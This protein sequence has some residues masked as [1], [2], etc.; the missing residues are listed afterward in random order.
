M[1]PGFK[2]TDWEMIAEACSP[3][4]ARRDGAIQRLFEAYR[5]PIEAWLRQCGSDPQ[6]SGELAQDFFV[7]VIMERDL[8]S[9]ADPA[10]GKLRIL[11]KNAARRYRIDSIR[12]ES[13]RQRAE[14]G[15]AQR[16]GA[17]CS[18]MPSDAE[19]DAE[20][21]RQQLQ[22]ALNRAR[23]LM[24][25]TGRDREWAVFELAVLMP[26]VHGTQRP[27]MAEIARATGLP[28][29]EAASNLLLQA[30][31]RVQAMFKEVVSETVGAAGDFQEELL[32][33]ESVLGAAARR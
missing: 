28:G 13:A 4:I 3:S 6:R 23:D 12:R 11:L 31:R 19:F 33:V 29:A 27:P 8:L 1:E 16:D 7:T 24:L 14:S 15:A 25:A 5:A 17:P 18:S 9:A 26:S 2:T 10:K 20:W 22:I 32:H 30:R 21:A